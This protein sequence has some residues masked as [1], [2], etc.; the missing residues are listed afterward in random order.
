[1]LILRRSSRVI[2]SPSRSASRAA[3]A[4]GI[5]ATVTYSNTAPTGLTGATGGASGSGGNTDYYNNNPSTQ[6]ALNIASGATT[7]TFTVGTGSAGADTDTEAFRATIALDAA[8]TLLANLIDSQG[9]GYILDNA[10][11]G[12]A[13]LVSDGV[14]AETATHATFEITLSDRNNTAADMVLTLG[15]GGTATAG[16]DYTNSIEIRTWNFGTSTWSAWSTYSASMTILTGANYTHSAVEARVALTNDNLGEANETITLTATR[17]SGENPINTGDTFTGTITIVDD[18]V[19]P[20]VSVNDAAPVLEGGTAS[21]TVSLSQASLQDITVNWTTAG[22][23]ATSGTDFTAVGAGTLTILAGSTT[24]TISV[25]TL[26]NS[27]GAAL[28]NFTVTLTLPGSMTNV[29]TLGDATATGYIVDPIAVE[30]PTFVVSNPSMAEATNAV[31]EIS[32]SKASDA[33]VTLDL[34]LVS[35]TAISGSD[36]AAGLEVST[37]GLGGPWTSATAV[38]IAAGST[39]AWVRTTT[40]ADGLSENNESF[41]LTATRTAGTTNNT[42]ASGTAT[43]VG[44]IAGLVPP[45]VSVAD[46]FVDESAGTATVTISLSQAGSQSITVDWATADGTATQTYDYLASSGSVVFAPG[47]ISKTLTINLVDDNVAEAT[48]TVNVNL[49]LN[50]GSAGLATIGDAQAVVSIRDTDASQDVSVTFTTN[51][52]ASGITLAGIQR[53]SSVLNSGTVTYDAANGAGVSSSND[54]PDDNALGDLERLLVTFDRATYPQGVEGVKFYLTRVGTGPVTFTIFDI[55]GNELGQYA[56]NMNGTTGSRWVELPKEF[57]NVGSVMILAGTYNYYQTNPTLYVRDVAFDTSINSG[58]VA[59]APELIQYTLT[60]TDGDSSTASLT[61]STVTNNLRGT[62]GNDTITGTNANDYISGLDGDDTINAGTGA[63]IIVGGAGIDTI[64]GDA[65]DDVIAGGT[66]N[67]V[68]YGDAGS[69]ILRGD[70]GDDTLDGGIGADRLEGGAG[71]DTL[72]GG[73]GTDTLSGGAGND[74]LTG[75]LLSDTFEWTLGDVGARGTPAVDTITD[76]NPA[77]QA[78]GGDVLD[79]RDLL[80]GENHTVGTGNL[81]NFLHFEQVGADAKV[82]ISSTGAFG[83]GF[84][85]GAEDQTIVL[86]GVNVY[87]DLG[88]SVNATDQQVI[89]DLLTKGKLIVD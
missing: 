69:D 29:A 8:N 51:P 61:L 84:T 13:I 57:S 44:D 74:T 5:N 47:E 89:Q 1:M 73:D 71:T 85:T 82:H 80:S 81:A 62:T 60:D 6:V 46:L 48:Q 11:T 36:F 41:Q 34:A 12:S 64:H 17:T 45:V 26:A 72:T 52:S 42:S 58:A 31:F 27:D 77:S 83:G 16:T 86:T 33:A 18:E 2:R 4:S 65:D 78:S 54:N 87:T 88:L 30:S 32:L 49:T 20:V 35:G 14:V 53:D 21:F 76:F 43:I 70:V 59:I 56:V 66:G 28:E 10:D 55:H 37:A 68:L 3:P 22:G 63:D 50:A 40:T 9:F 15:L 67:D 24:G 75:G 38:T 7:G 79:L 23:T 25:T 19:K 39:T